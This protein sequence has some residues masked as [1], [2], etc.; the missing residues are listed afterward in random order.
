MIR[1]NFVTGSR[2]ISL[3]AVGLLA[4]LCVQ[5]FAE[6][7]LFKR[8]SRTRDCATGSVAS[9]GFGLA[10]EEGQYQVIEPDAAYLTVNVP[11][12]NL[13]TSDAELIIN[14]D[15]TVSVGPSR[16]FIVRDL[17]PEKD[18]EFQIVAI[19][20]NRANVERM[21]VK[22]ITLRAGDMQTL[23]LKPTRRRSLVEQELEE[24]G[25]KQSGSIGELLE[26]VPPV[27]ND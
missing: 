16:R 14:G 21:E 23:S 19:T 5:D 17:E 22:T 20:A 4:S 12:V 7:Q 18:Y 27:V 25:Q 15:P 10:F 2:W 9:Q 13:D 24:F 1:I 8:F 3:S 6:A 11:E 26:S